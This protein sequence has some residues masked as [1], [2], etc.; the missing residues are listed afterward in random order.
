MTPSDGDTI[1]RILQ[2]R[3]GQWTLVQLGDGRRFRVFDIAWGRDMGDEYDHITTNISPGPSGEHTVDFFFASE[4]ARI[5]DAETRGVLFEHEHT[6][7]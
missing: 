5:E 1:S 2:E 6:K 7:A 3:C 4:V